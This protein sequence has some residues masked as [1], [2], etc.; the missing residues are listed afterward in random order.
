MGEPANTLGDYVDLGHGRCV[1]CSRDGRV[2]NYT[3]SLLDIHF[4][5]V[6]TKGGI[7]AYA[8]TGMYGANAFK[9]Y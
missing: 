7:G 3:E 5:R 2:S 6:V 1:P 4:M 9:P 8:S